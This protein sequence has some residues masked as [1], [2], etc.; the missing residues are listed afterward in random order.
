MRPA[1]SAIT[2]FAAITLIGA[3]SDDKEIEEQKTESN[4]ITET[5]MDD[6]DALEGTISDEMIITDQS[7]EEGALA[8][9]DDEK[10]TADKGNKGAKGE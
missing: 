7:S 6:I 1:L 5:R 10:S 3:C 8:S 9:G 2:L 4:A